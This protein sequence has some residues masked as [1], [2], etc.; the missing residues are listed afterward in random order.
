M[1][2]SYV[3]YIE[4]QAILLASRLSSRVSP[5]ISHKDFEFKG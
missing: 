5:K 4:G 1:S 3:N 2:F